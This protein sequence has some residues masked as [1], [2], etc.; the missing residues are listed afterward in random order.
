MFLLS[1]ELVDNLPGQIASESRRRDEQPGK[2]ASLAVHSA[3]SFSWCGFQGSLGLQ[4]QAHG[5]ACAKTPPRQLDWSTPTPHPSGL[6]VPY[7]G[8]ADGLC[9]TVWFSE[10]GAGLTVY[11]IHRSYERVKRSGISKQ[12]QRNGEELD[13]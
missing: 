10:L 3:M 1:A 2:P 4:G 7:T 12:S 6:P 11:S 13:V 5:T 8:E 9:R